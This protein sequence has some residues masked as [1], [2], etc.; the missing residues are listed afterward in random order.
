N[1]A[2]NYEST[3]LPDMINRYTTFYI[4]RTFTVG[5]PLDTNLALLLTVDYDDG[6]VAYLDGTEIRRA[7]TTN[8]VG[9][10]ITFTQT[11]GANSHEASCCN[12][13][14]NPATTYDLGAIGN[15]LA[16]GTHVL[17]IVGLN[18]SSGSSDFH[19][20]ADLSVAGGTGSTVSGA[21]GTL[22]TSNAVTLTGS[23]T[24]AGST[25]VAINNED[26]GYTPADGRWSQTRSLRPGM[27]QLYIAALDAG[28]N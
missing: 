20:I 14:V 1:S 7:N 11:T 27:N 21:F 15:R 4:R 16:V 19:L 13:P 10:V 8:G 2:A 24:V 28:G 23:N 6:F 5:S 18:Q 9:S 25:R 17:A 12:A 22:V 3:M 26:A